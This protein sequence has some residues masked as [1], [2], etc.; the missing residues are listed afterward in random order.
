MVAMV[1]SC[2]VL[3]LCVSIGVYNFSPTY[4]IVLRLNAHVIR[5]MSGL[6]MLTIEE[7]H[8]FHSLDRAL[9]WFIH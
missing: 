7:A 1:C 5:R 9:F 6:H 8:T 4:P 3:C 2:V